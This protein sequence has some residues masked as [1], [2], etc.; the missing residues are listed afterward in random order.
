MPRS[1]AAR[2]TPV[3]KESLVDWAMFTCVF[4]LTTPYVPL[5][6]PSSSRARFAITSLVFMLIDVPAPPW[7]GSTMNH[8]SSLP[9]MTS[10][11]AAAIAFAIFGVEVAGVAVRERRRLLHDPHGPDQRRM[12]PVRR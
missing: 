1:I 11:A 12:D 3:G 2:W 10:S 9:A 4:G 6:W 5:G 8:S 7:I